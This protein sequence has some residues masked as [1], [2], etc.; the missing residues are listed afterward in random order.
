[1]EASISPLSS[2]GSSMFSKN[3]EPDFSADECDKASPSASF[4]WDANFD[5]SHCMYPGIGLRVANVCSKQ[6]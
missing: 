6:D 1:M 2:S 3:V 5:R 4:D